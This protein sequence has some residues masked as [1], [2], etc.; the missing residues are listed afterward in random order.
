MKEILYDFYGY[1]ESW[2]AYLNK[3]CSHDLLQTIF[4][5]LSKIFDIEHFAIYYLIAASF[6]FFMKPEAFSKYYDF[7]V[8]LGIGYACFGLLYALLKF[9]MNMPRPFCSGIEFIT[10]MDI[11]KE[12]CWSSFPSSHTGLAMLLTLYLWPYIG[13]FTR[14]LFVLL[15][16]LVGISRIALAM[17]YPADIFYSLFIALLVYIIAT[18]VYRLFQHNLIALVKGWLVKFRDD[19]KLNSRVGRE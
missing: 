3:L 13:I 12:R 5:N 6:G 9:T 16:S 10:I 8:R 11:A 2:F 1:N 19:D 17:H 4:Y 15:I 14:L 7:M 18:A